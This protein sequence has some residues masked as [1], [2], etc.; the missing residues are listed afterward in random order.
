[1]LCVRRRR[2]R[3]GG[4]GHELSH[5]PLKIIGSKPGQGLGKTGQGFVRGKIEGTERARNDEAQ[6]AR[7][8]EF[9]RSIKPR[10]QGIEQVGRTGNGA[11]V[12]CDWPFDRNRARR[13]QPNH[14]GRRDAGQFAAPRAQHHVT[15]DGDGFGVVDPHTGR[16]KIGEGELGFVGRHCRKKIATILPYP[17]E[18][19]VPGF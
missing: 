18:A 15:Y 12:G 10:K 4:T 7:D 19:K 3:Q 8:T 2:G 13:I 14:V 1:V 6:R 5:D 9:S 11:I 16:R 17:P